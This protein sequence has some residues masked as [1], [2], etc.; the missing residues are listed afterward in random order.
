MTF[1]LDKAFGAS[2]DTLMRMQN[3]YDI[4]QAHTREGEIKV[5][6]YKPKSGTPR[7]SNLF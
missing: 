1:R 6:R 4:A 5:A 7:P 3:R 2:T